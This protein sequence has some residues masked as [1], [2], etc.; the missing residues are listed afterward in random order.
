M[1][2]QVVDSEKPLSEKEIA[3]LE[4]KIGHRL[5][6]GYRSFLATYNGGY[7]QGENAFRYKLQSGPYT[8]SRLNHLFS[9]NDDYGSLDKMYLRMSKAGR[10]PKNLF[11]I[12]NDAFGNLICISLS[13]KDTSSVYFWDHENEPEDEDTEFRNI[14]LIADSWEEFINGLVTPE[15]LM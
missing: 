5:P 14:H 11:P 13:G 2:L 15:S 10:T 8:D 12:A 9:L 6:S 1:P 4:K 7:A 3:A